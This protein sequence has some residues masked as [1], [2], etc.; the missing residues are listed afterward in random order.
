M[1]LCYHFRNIFGCSEVLAHAFCIVKYRSE[2]VSPCF[3]HVALH[4]RFPFHSAYVLG[5]LAAFSIHFACLLAPDPAISPSKMHATI[6][7]EFGF[8][9]SSLLVAFWRPL[10]SLWPPKVAKMAAK[11]LPKWDPKAI[12]MPLETLSPSGLHFGSFLAPCW[13]SFWL[14]GGFIL[15][16]SCHNFGVVLRAGFRVASPP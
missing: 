1:P 5:L 11:W 4:M 9:V 15:R 2:C 6:K 7:I 16:P 12:L 8:D 3:C 14:E 13:F 10:P